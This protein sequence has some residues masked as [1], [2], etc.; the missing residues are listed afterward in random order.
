MVVRLPEKATA[1]RP[2][3]AAPLPTSRPEHHKTQFYHSLSRPGSRST[4]G[5]FFTL[6]EISFNPE[7]TATANFPRFNAVAVGS[8]LNER[9]TDRSGEREGRAD[10]FSL[11]EATAVA[12]L[13][14]VAAI[15]R[16]RCHP[17]A[18]VKTPFS[19][20]SLVPVV[21]TMVGEVFR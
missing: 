14:P 21:E 6:G 5:Q 20:L 16:Y 8:G 4:A 2:R 15:G 18:F 17:R 11:A 13:Q 9:K 10:P 7:P 12:D 3:L 1:D 19:P